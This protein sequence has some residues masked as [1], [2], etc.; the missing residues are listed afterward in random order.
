MSQITLHET[1]APTAKD[2]TAAL[3][4]LRSFT[5]ASV[6]KLD[7]HDYALLLKKEDGTLVGGLIA[8]SRWG[9]FHIAILALA[10]GLRGH[11]FGSSM[12][13]KAEAEA[14]KRGC[15]HLWLDTYAYQAKAFYERHGFEVYGQIDGPEPYYPHY[16]MIKRL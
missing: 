6:P 11:G 1:D 5:R 12:M 13:K 16:F 8:Q 7:N 4:V 15:Q 3:E 9:G 2:A 10:D 14:R